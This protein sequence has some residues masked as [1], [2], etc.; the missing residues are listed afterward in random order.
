[1]AQNHID[2]PPVLP[3]SKHSRRRRAAARSR[4]AHVVVATQNLP[5]MSGAI[6]ALIQAGYLVTAYA[7]PT[8]LLPRLHRMGSPVALLVIDGGLAPAFARAAA[9]AARA[10][11][12]NLPIIL[13]ASPQATRCTEFMPAGVTVLPLPLSE[14]GLLSA[15][16]MLA[17]G[18][19]DWLD[20]P[21]DAA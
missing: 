7:S 1:M 19:R 6:Q 4:E 18:G 2:L 13:L 12:E 14:S 3:I 21:P 20:E 15:A 16:A 8:R 9:I 11:Y 5:R 10:T 17:R